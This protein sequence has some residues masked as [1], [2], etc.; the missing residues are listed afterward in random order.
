MKIEPLSAARVIHHGQRYRAVHCQVS[1][2]PLV[3]VNFEFWWPAPSREPPPTAQEFFTARGINFVG[4]RGARND[5]FQHD[6]ILE[7]LEAV[8]AATPGGRRVGYG[9]SMGGY[10]VIN[11][12]QDLGLDSLVA[13]CPQF[14]IDPRK[15][16]FEPRWRDEAAAIAFRHDKIDRIAPIRHGY[17][18]FDPATVDAAHMAMITRRHAITPIRMHFAGHDVLRMLTGAGVAA[19]LLIGLVRD[20]VDHAGF[21]RRLRAT[22]A[23]YAPFWLAAAEARARRGHARAALR[24]IVRAKAQALPDPP[25]ADIAHA[26]ILR[27][28]GRIEEALALLAAHPDVAIADEMRAWQVRHLYARVAGLE[29][30]VAAM[31]S[32]LSWRLT[33]PLRA[34]NGWLRR[35]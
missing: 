30:Q 9:G 18:I 29:A 7:V 32:S 10:A 24:A 13:V 5:W 34:I 21:V 1:D 19:E 33:A 12:A 2:D 8:R 3:V 17:A 14:S 23:T 16:P 22:R 26:I 6:E 31:T 4:V 27:Q 35:R 15:A 28:H 11:F 25:R 20:T